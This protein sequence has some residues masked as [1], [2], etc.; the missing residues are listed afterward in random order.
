MKQ[1]VPKIKLETSWRTKTQ[2]PSEISSLR[3]DDWGK[4]N[5]INSQM[6]N[7][8]INRNSQ[9]KTVYRESTCY[10]NSIRITV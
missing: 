6:E 5:M 1:E 4:Q 8:K 7:H 3:N 9:T 2:V 10:T